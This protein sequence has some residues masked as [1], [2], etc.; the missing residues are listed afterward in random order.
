MQQYAPSLSFHNEQE[1]EPGPLITGSVG[2][3]GSCGG[4]GGVARSL[5]HWGHCLWSL[6][7]AGGYGGIVRSC[8]LLGNVDGSSEGLI[9][10]KV[11]MTLYSL[12]V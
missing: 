2:S 10:K 12:T 1:L 3:V 11:L 9:V 4:S 7:H 6:G 5:G 8:T